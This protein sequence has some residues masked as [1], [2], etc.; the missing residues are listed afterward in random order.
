MSK[1]KIRT[2]QYFDFYCPA[3]KRLHT[4]SDSAG[5][6][7]GRDLLNPTITPSVLNQTPFLTNK[8]VDGKIVEKMEYKDRCHLF[9]TNGKIHYCSDC[10]HEFAGKIVDMQSV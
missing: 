6:D 2:I 10:D 5:W 3:C 9:V 8:I 4:V 7:V 1:I